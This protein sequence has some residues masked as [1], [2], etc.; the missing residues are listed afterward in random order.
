MT[1]TYVPNYPQVRCVCSVSRT[2][3]A[4]PFIHYDTEET[5]PPLS[6][7]EALSSAESEVERSKTI[8]STHGHI[9][10]ADVLITDAVML[11]PAVCSRR[12][13]NTGVILPRD[14]VG[15]VQVS[16]GR[17]PQSVICRWPFWVLNNVYMYI[18]SDVYTCLLC[19]QV[20]KHCRQCSPGSLPQNCR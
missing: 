1:Q 13:E 10:W 14:E 16:Q 6:C 5:P 18:I 17:L 11:I 7:F 20:T 15:G 4:P 2:C 9:A 3:A 8:H 19:S 12:S